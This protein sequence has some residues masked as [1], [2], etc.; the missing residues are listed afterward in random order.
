MKGRDGLR[1][2]VI[3]SPFLVGLQLTHAGQ[4]DFGAVI[5]GFARTGDRGLRFEAED[6]IE[7]YRAFVSAVRM[8]GRADG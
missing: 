5:P 6:P 8:A 1:P 4:R 7:A 3:E 2:L